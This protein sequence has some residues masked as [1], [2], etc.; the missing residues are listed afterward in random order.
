LTTITRIGGVRVYDCEAD[1]GARGSGV[2]TGERRPECLGPKR[3]E[4]DR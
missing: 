4:R 2:F 1:E 3:S